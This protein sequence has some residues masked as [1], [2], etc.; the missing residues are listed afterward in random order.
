MDYIYE[1]DRC[2]WIG[3]DPVELAGDLWDYTNHEACPICWE[4]D[5]VDNPVYA[6]EVAA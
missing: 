6:Y 4:K 5:A 3:R 1:C 2:G